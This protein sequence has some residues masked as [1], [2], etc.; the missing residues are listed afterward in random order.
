MLHWKNTPIDQLS[1]TQLQSALVEAIELRLK[2]NTGFHHGDLFS[3]F[4]T[5]LFTG[6]GISIVAILINSTI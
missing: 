2:S 4:S 3:T 6:I 1:K 5:G